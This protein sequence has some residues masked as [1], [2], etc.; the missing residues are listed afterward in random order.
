MFSYFSSVRS[1][2]LPQV[3][4]TMSAIVMEKHGGINV[5][6]M[7][8]KFPRQLIPRSQEVII[9]VAAAGLNPVDFKLRI[10]PLHSF[11]LPKPKI[12]GADVSGIIMYASPKSKFKTGDRV[13]GLLPLIKST[14]GS[15][16]EYVCID[17]SYVTLAPQNVPLK[18]LASIPLVGST[19]IQAMKPIIKAFHN[20]TKGKKCFIQAGSGGVGT[21]AI[22]Y[23]AKVLGMHVLTTCSPR[24]DQLLKDLGASET[25]D[26]HTEEIESKV[27]DYDVFIDTMSYVYESIVL[28][29]K[30]TILR[31]DPLNPSHYVHIASSPYGGSTARGKH[32][33]NA[34]MRKDPF[35]LVFL[36][37]E[38]IE[39]Y[40]RKQRHCSII[41]FYLFSTQYLLVVVGI[42][43]RYQERIS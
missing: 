34:T 11:V 29:S 25:I 12:L 40:Y 26:Y 15:Y 36:T 41:G 33:L 9:K 8:T 24:N 23:C 6:N 37:S 13:F 7:N 5:L 21:F 20:N 28:D 43:T 16:A 42:G 22:Q 35:P 38:S 19:V 31:R 27:Q 3:T 30:S 39:C 1:T 18:D 10:G 14:Y 4:P 2:H 32:N 17:E